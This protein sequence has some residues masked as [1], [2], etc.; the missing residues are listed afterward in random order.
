MISVAI[1]ANFLVILTWLSISRSRIHQRLRIEIFILLLVVLGLGAYAISMRFEEGLGAA[2]NLSD[3]FP[4]GLWI[5]FDLCGVALAAGGFVLAA[6]VH[7]FKLRK[8]EPMLKPAVLTSLISYSLV[9]AILVLDLGR[10]Y[11]FWHPLIMWQPHSAMF[12]ITLCITFYT[13]ILFL[14]FSPVL[15]EKLSWHRAARAVH[16]GV[17]PL[18]IV[19]AVLSTLHQSSFG[20]LFLIAPEKISPIWYTPILPF[21]FLISA[22]AV[23]MAVIIVESFICDKLLDKKLPYALLI[24]LA[25]L[26]GK[27][28]WLYIFVKMG[29]FFLR[30]VWK[31]ILREPRLGFSFLLEIIGGGFIPAVWMTRI[32]KDSEKRSLFLASLMVV[33]GTILNRLNICWFGLFPYTKPEFYFPS[34][35]EIFS[36]AALVVTGMIAFVVI[37]RFL[38]VFSV[39]KHSP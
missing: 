10:P 24:D 34:W 8:F 5:A 1:A 21:L 13:M 38:P 2:T 31:E 36:T 12:E 33:G 14:E 4:W 9:A 35:M 6:S 7:I 18:V 20:S 32:T 30:G 16:Q 28:L 17:I 25:R 23:G 39:D 15:F 27:I 26:C 37:S 19:G 22:I 29:D 3:I 11:R